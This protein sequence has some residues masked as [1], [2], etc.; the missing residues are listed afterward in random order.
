LTSTLFISLLLCVIGLG[1]RIGL[2]VWTGIDRGGGRR[3]RTIGMRGR[4]Y[5]V[6]KRSNIG[7]VYCTLGKGKG[8][9]EGKIVACS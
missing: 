8:E 2:L 6:S 3:R 7:N 4:W 9:E 1:R 5:E